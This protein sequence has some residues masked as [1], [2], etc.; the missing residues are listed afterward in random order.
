VNLKAVEKRQGGA[1]RRARDRIGSMSLEAA[2]PCANCQRLQAQLD[3]L[4][5]KQAELGAA[6]AQLQAQLAAARK[7]S[8]TSS[9]P[10]SSDIV[11]PPKPAPPAGQQKRPS[12]GQPGHP[13][14][15]R[16]PLPPGQLTA[17]P[18]DYFF[19]EICPDCGHGLRPAGDEVR[20][21][22]QIEI[23]II[24][25]QVEEHRS[26]PGW[27]PNCC[28]VH[29]PALPAEVE[30]GGLVGPRLTAL[31]AFLKGFCHASYSTVRKFLRDVAGVSISRGLLQKVIFKVSEALRGPYQELLDCLPSESVVNADETG[32]RRNKARMW[33][34]CFRAS[35]YTLFKIDPRRSADVLLGV[36]GEEF[37]GVLGCDHFSAYR[38]YMRE[39]GVAVQFCLAHLIREVKFLL[40]LPDRREQ[41]YGERLRQA[42][43]DLFGV[44]HRRDQVAPWVFALRLKE[45]RDEVL[46]QGTQD[47]PPTRHAQTMAR[48]LSKYGASYFTFVTTPG[49]EPTN[50]L[51]EQAI[52]FVVI[53]RLITQGTRSEKGDRWCERIWTVI[54][55]CAQQGKSVFDYLYDAVEAYFHNEKAPSLL[56]DA[57]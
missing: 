50:N 32:H 22:Q 53:D 33:T 54:A 26:H 1:I 37:D 30:K 49:V 11:K 41:A 47:V 46:R 17:P 39:C 36:L 48:R 44:I 6:L 31:I 10:P 42:L 19:P 9:K 15:E 28:Q 21:V 4:Q 52:R 25:V 8:S 20:V 43:R 51:A 7:D 13:K 56:P 12:G 34:W 23:A 24:P 3:A 2:T 40:T 55:T 16:A 14:H 27:C 18:H 35:L 57:G 38:R 45:A 29:Y 5:A